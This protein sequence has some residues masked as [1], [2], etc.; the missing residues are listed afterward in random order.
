[1]TDAIQSRADN[2]VRQF[3]DSLSSEVR[4]GLSAS[5]YDRL[6]AIVRGALSEQRNE[7]AEHIEKLARAMRAGVESPDLGL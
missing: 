7:A 3:K 4:E 2:V 1:M 6:N 5:D